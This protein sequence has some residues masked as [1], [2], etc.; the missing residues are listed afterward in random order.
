MTA[1]R[2]GIGSLL[3]MALAAGCGGGL[4]QPG[5]DTKIVRLALSAE[6]GRT[7]LAVNET[8]ALTA[9]GISASGSQVDA[10]TVTWS[11]DEAA[12]LALQEGRAKGLRSGTVKVTAK[13]SEQSATL[14]LKVEGAL[15][16]G[17]VSE[18]ETWRAEDNPHR[19]LDGNAYVNGAS[20]PTL[21]I[22]AGVLVQFEE[23]TSL[24]IG[25]GE[26]GQLVVLGTE[27]DPVVFTSE[28]AIPQPGDWAGLVFGDAGDGD[29]SHLHVMYGGASAG[30]GTEAC[31]QV[32]AE[33][34]KPVFDH[35]SVTRCADDGIF[36]GALAG[37]GAGSTSLHLAHNGGHPVAFDAP[38][39]VGTMPP[40][41]TFE[42]NAHETIHINGGG[43]SRTQTWARHAIPYSVH[44]SVVEIGGDDR[45]VLT[46]APGVEIRFGTSTGIRAWG[47]ELV[48]VGTEQ[49]KITFTS[50]AADRQPGQW[51]GIVFDTGASV[52]SRLEYAVVE[53]G[54][55]GLGTGF[56]DGNVSV[57]EDKGPIVKHTVL[58]HSAAWGIV[59]GGLDF[60]TD[61][62]ATTQANVFE[63]NATGPQSGT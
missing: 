1:R 13:A 57:F 39:F 44:Q 35:V 59:R 28:K 37:F 7:T 24:V 45:P 30:M 9:V 62:T 29:L 8:L 41:S 20:S 31:I 21:T 5:D 43:V 14:T 26:A 48:A 60:V 61:F 22:E 17:T 52:T 10:G 55:G 27:E 36:L 16:G 63:S 12:R 15:H 2:L 51:G 47:G 23:G 6:G 25:N 11:V 33:H 58:R 40:N 32:V 38:E 4:D 3:L 34:D 42:E 46:L 19:V 49:A 56:P 50:N 53:Y 18:D 54:G